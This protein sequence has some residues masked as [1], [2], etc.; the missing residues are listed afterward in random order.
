MAWVLE[1]DPPSDSENDNPFLP[2]ALAHIVELNIPDSDLVFPPRDLASYTHVLAPGTDQQNVVANAT[3]R[4]TTLREADGRARAVDVDDGGE[5]DMDVDDAA[6][7]TSSNLTEIGSLE[8]PE[9]FE[10]RGERLFHSHGRSKYPFPVDG[11]ECKRMDAIHRILLLAAGKNYEGPVGEVL[12]NDEGGEKK[13]VV[14]LCTGT[15]SWTMEMAHEFPHIEFRGLDVVPIATRYPLENVRFEMADVNHALRFR[16]ASVDLVHARMTSLAIEDHPALL[17]EVARILR[18]G[19]LFLSCEWVACPALHPA[20]PHRAH[21]DAYIPNT[22][23]LSREV[24]R[25]LNGEQACIPA[26]IRDTRAF[27][28]PVE[29]TRVLPIG[30]PFAPPGSPPPSDGLQHIGEAMRLVA[31]GFAAS[32]AAAAASKGQREGERVAAL[33]EEYK[34]EIDEKSGLVAVWRTVWARKV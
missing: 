34:R 7:D 29:T 13:M 14:D 16:A 19:G 22:T 30:R 27:T 3:V 25:L 18:P 21:P 17:R 2:N 11:P 32:V 24:L 10:Q 26:L 33:A 9:Y 31:H 15:G 4:P 1:Q 28:P 8:F 5:E 23:R 6:S 12:A 20:H